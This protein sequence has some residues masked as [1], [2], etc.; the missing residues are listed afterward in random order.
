MGLLTILFLL[1]EKVVD[2]QKDLQK[3]KLVEQAIPVEVDESRLCKNGHTWAEVPSINEK[4]E[5]IQLQICDSCGLIPSRNLMSKPET[6]IKVRNNVKAAQLDNK[7]IEDF[8]THEE[9]DMREIF[10]EELKSGTDFKKVLKVYNAGQT[11]RE[12]YIMYRLGRLEEL[13]VEKEDGK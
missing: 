5:Y 3:K 1:V 10:A 2:F 8:S 6:M 9:E 12:R 13:K 11:F 4:G 7:I